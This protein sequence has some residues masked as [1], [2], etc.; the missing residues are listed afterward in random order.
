M[1]VFA[2]ACYVVTANGILDYFGQTVNIAARLQGASGPGEIVIDGAFADLAESAG[3]LSGFT[4]R[5]H[6]EARLK[7]LPDPV[8][9]ARIVA[10]SA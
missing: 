3:W 4:I 1:G 9:V 8:R 7:G 5:E 2:G 6:F 10:D